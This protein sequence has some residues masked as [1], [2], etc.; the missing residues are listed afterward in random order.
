MGTKP[1]IGFLLFSNRLGVTQIRG[2][3]DDNG[4]AGF[5]IFFILSGLGEQGPEVCLAVVPWRTLSGPI[6]GCDFGGGAKV[7]PVGG[8]QEP[9]HRLVVILPY[10]FT[11]GVTDSESVLRGSIP[12]KSMPSQVFDAGADVGLSQR[13]SFGRL[14]AGAGCELR[15]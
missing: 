9:S 13:A 8:F 7:A 15:D 4:P 11:A 14:C 3:L 10:T 6:T 5:F 1:F 12:L 2:A